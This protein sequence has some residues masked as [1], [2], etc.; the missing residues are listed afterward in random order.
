M[1]VPI[2][3]LRQVYGLCHTQKMSIQRLTEEN[4]QLKLD[5]Q[6][7]ADALKDAHTRDRAFRGRLR[8]V[9]TEIDNL[10]STQNKL[11][12]NNKQ[13]IKNLLGGIESET[14]DPATYFTTLTRQ[15]YMQMVGAYTTMCMYSK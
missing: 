12:E 5:H 15:E 8:E 3:V 6:V 10:R 7:L 2:E 14:A 9:K 4:R 13:L 1:M 11:N